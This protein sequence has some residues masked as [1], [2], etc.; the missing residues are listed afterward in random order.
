MLQ[1]TGPHL[2]LLS[3]CGEREHQSLKCVNDSKMM[4]NHGGQGGQTS[5]LWVLPTFISIINCVPRCAHSLLSS[6]FVFFTVNLSFHDSLGRT[7]FLS[8]HENR[9]L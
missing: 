1:P 6:V 9:E 2:V 8:G 7:T 4:T 5:E 3:Q